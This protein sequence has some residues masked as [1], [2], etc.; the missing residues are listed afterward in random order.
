MR[1]VEVLEVVLPEVK[2]GP[3]VEI[4]LEDEEEGVVEEG[5][6]EGNGEKEEE[7]K[8]EEEEEGNRDVVRRC[9]WRCAVAPL[10][11]WSAAWGLARFGLRLL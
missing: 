9:L 11:F 2:D 7:E 1:A 3:V 6:G 10:I 5:D 4:R 8:E